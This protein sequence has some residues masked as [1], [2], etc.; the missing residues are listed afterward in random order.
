MISVDDFVLRKPSASIDHNSFQQAARNRFN[1]NR[2]RTSNF[3]NFQY[4][5]ESG[6]GPGGRRFKSSLPDHLF[7]SR[8]KPS[9]VL[10]IPAVGK[11]ATVLT[12]KIL[13]VESPGNGQMRKTNKTATIIPE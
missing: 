10:K 3:H 7:S 1:I 12:S 8:Y 13:L 5:S 9:E 2:L 11:N 4:D 6:S